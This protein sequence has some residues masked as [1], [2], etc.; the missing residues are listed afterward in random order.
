MV[1]RF[2]KLAVMATI[3]EDHSRSKKRLASNLECWPY[4]KNVRFAEKI[5][6][7]EDPSKWLA[8]VSLPNRIVRIEPNLEKQDCCTAFIGANNKNH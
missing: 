3:L 2:S 8:I 1:P 4:D 6:K 7:V 5:H